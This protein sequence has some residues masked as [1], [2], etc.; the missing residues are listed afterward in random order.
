MNE[1]DPRVKRTRKLLMGAFASLLGEKRF[2]DISVQDIAERATVNRATFY[3][4]FVDKYALLDAAFGELFRDTVTSR[5]SPDA[6]F[7]AEHLRALIVTVLRSQA[8]F[9]DHCQH[10][11]PGRDVS[12]MMEAKIQQELNTFLLEWLRRSLPGRRPRVPIE[13][14]A[15][16]MSWAIFGTAVEWSGGARALSAD[17]RASQVAAL[18]MD[19]LARTIDVEAAAAGGTQ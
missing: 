12:P 1:T 13:H 3:A 2:S 4:H 18:L 6:P 17:E 10:Q 7:T 9:H 5:V 8:Q 15:S 11:A 14:L 19:G 16:V